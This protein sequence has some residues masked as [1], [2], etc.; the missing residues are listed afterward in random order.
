M[1]FN[2]FE[3]HQPVRLTTNDQ[4]FKRWFRV[5]DEGVPVSC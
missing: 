5:A 1:A 2:P 3:Q 4:I